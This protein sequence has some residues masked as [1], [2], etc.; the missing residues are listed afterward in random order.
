MTFLGNYKD[1]EIVVPAVITEDVFHY[2]V[3]E[4]L[5]FSVGA[6]IL[7]PS[8]DQGVYMTFTTP[9]TDNYIH[10][11]PEITGEDSVELHIRE[12][13]TPTS[14]AT[15]ADLV[16]YNKNRAATYT[17]AT[18][19]VIAGNTSTAG[20]VQVQSGHAPTTTGTLIYN[21]FQSKASGGRSAT[22]ELLL[23]KNTTYCFQAIARVGNKNTGLNLTWFE[24]PKA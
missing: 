19:G 15:T 1:D 9:N 13:Y 8:A 3:H 22:Y 7:T 14:T 4:G 5:A 16:A 12:G 18:S 2:A 6:Y 21:E 24:I 10:I 17:S 23:E 11:I 20:A